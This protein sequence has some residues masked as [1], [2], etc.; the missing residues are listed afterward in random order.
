MDRCRNA[1][2]QLVVWETS[3][4]ATLQTALGRLVG[5]T[6]GPGDVQLGLE[7]VRLCA[8]AHVRRR[9]A[10]EALAQTVDAIFAREPLLLHPEIAFAFGL[11]DEQE[12]LKAVYRERRKGSS[13]PVQ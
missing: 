1:G 6:F 8:L 9:F 3:A 13:P 12:Q 10:D 4:D 7:S 11:L 5:E 2:R